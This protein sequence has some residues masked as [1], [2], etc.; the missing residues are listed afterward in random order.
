MLEPEL[1]LAISAPAPERNNLVD[2]YFTLISRQFGE[3]ARINKKNLYF[4]L[5]LR[6]IS[7]DITLVGQIVLCM[8]LN[9]KVFLFLIGNIGLELEPK[10]K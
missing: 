8:L 4:L 7:D 5:K 10:P 6:N 2:K 3:D 9:Q 1:L